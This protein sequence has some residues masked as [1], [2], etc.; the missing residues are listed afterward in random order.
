MPKRLEGVPMRQYPKERIMASALKPPG[1]DASL[2]W[3]QASK[4]VSA[5][6]EEL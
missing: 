5:A 4:V 6:F 2:R 3:G 1:V